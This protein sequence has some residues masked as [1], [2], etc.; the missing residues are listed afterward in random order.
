MDHCITYLKCM[1]MG[2]FTEENKSFFLPQAVTTLQAVKFKTLIVFYFI[3][4]IVQRFYKHSKNKKS[5]IR[6]RIT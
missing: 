1:Y 4:T 2:L 3:P 6:R 5:L